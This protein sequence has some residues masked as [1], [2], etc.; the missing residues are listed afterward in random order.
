ML[1]EKKK[2]EIGGVT[3]K[4][5]NLF[6]ITIFRKITCS[7]EGWKKYV[8]FGVPIYDSDGLSV[9]N[10]VENFT[11]VCIGNRHKNEDSAKI[12]VWIEWSNDLEFLSALKCILKQSFRNFEIIVSYDAKEHVERLVSGYEIDVIY[13]DGSNF[14]DGLK[15]ATGKY[16]AF[17]ESGD[18]FVD[19][20]LLLRAE[21]LARYEYPRVIFNDACVF[22]KSVYHDLIK[23]ENAKDRKLLPKR[24]NRLPDEQWRKRNCLYS[25]SCLLIDREV[26][27]S[28]DLN[29]PNELLIDWWI[30]RQVCKNN[31][32]VML[33]E[34]LAVLGV[35]ESRIEKFNLHPI[36]KELLISKADFLMGCRAKRDLVF[37]KR[38]VNL[39][40]S[41]GSFVFRTGRIAVFASFNPNGVVDEFVVYYLRELKKVVDG[42]IFVC[43]NPVFPEE[44]KKIEPYV[45]Y[46][47]CH[48]HGEYD[49]GSYKIGMNYIIANNLVGSVNELI[50]CNDSCYGSVS[51]FQ[52]LFSLMHERGKKVDFWGISR[53]SVVKNHIQSFFL[54]F[55]KRVISD[56]EFVNF[57][58]SVK[59]HDDVREVILNYEV[60]LTD[61][62]EKRGYVY[63]T[64]VEFSLTGAGSLGLDY[65]SLGIPLVKRKAI[66]GTYYGKRGRISGLLNRIRKNN[67]ELY[68]IIEKSQH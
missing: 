51:S 41:V 61:F 18:K 7:L 66:D 31:D 22:G 21:A 2:I 63:D 26:L 37:D 55:E 39:K 59:R 25:L 16:I 10:L 57:I 19:D 45:I 13:Y 44:L 40:R 38:C 60:E 17:C 9:R 24:V 34:K 49:F 47:D 8:F 43:D 5:Y 3:I 14:L 67:M 65:V 46:I 32:V 27:L 64:V 50:L 42:I 33:P 29:S 68:S 58:L 62:L 12:S 48:R 30:L 52:S 20:N 53:N 23:I 4:T 36:Y 1:F 56:P 28:C 6:N 15:S 54:V 11:P 35:S